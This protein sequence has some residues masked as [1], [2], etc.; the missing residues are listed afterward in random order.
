M[1]ERMSC[2]LKSFGCTAWIGESPIGTMFGIVCFTKFIFC[3]P[4]AN[5][6]TLLVKIFKMKRETPSNYPIVDRLS[7]LV[8]VEPN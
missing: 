1:A 6:N 3:R 5:K 4:V 7:G 2:F 8:G